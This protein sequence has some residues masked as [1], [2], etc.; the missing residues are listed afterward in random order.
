M[1]R[2]YIICTIEWNE[3]EMCALSASS[4]TKYVDNNHYEHNHY[5]NTKK[6]ISSLWF[7]QYTFGLCQ[8]TYC[9]SVCMCAG[10]FEDVLT[11]GLRG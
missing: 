3:R 4:Y 11:C 5:F 2:R 8:I 6:W 9:V 1:Y 7:I 10:F